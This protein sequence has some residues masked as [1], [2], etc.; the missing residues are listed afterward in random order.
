MCR[1]R[2][3]D[4]LEEARQLDNV[5][6]IAMVHALTVQSRSKCPSETSSTVP[7]A[8]SH[9]QKIYLGRYPLDLMR[10][11]AIEPIETV[12]PQPQ[13]LSLSSSTH[14]PAPLPCPVCSFIVVPS[15]MPGRGTSTSLA[16]P[17]T[18]LGRNAQSPGT[19]H[20]AIFSPL[21]PPRFCPAHPVA[22]G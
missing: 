15:L 17:H 6:T 21:V 1:D 16:P 13:A 10:I 7:K 3:H 19:Q 9:G 5:L 11:S 2:M 20:F 14:F 4:S 18:L 8:R 12:M 22:G